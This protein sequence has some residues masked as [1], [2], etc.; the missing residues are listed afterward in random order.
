M[1]RDEIIAANPI[2][3]FVRSRGHKMI[4]SGDNFITAACPV[5]VH[6]KPGHYPVT[7]DVAKQVW[8]C[9]DHKVGCSIIDW[10]KTEKNISAI[11]AMREL[12]GGE[13]KS[14]PRKEFVCA[15]DYTDESGKL[16]SQTVRYKLPSPENKTFSQRQPND[17]GGWIWNLKGVRCVLYR[18]REVVAAQTVIVVEG[19]KNADDLAALGFVATTNVFGA[20]KWR[21]EYSE[22]LRGK[23]VVV[24][25]DIGDPDQAG[26][27][28]TQKV[29]HSLAGKAG[30]LKH[31]IQ[32]NGFHDVSDWI[33]ALPKGEA[34]EAIQKLINETPLINQVDLWQQ[35]TT[36]Q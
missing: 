21:D 31:A 24:F 36:A 35:A 27:R 5:G 16:L 7:I 17:K 33:A 6:K 11:N 10:I 29:L 34:K 28:H 12:G 23:D 18:L 2:V 19:E 14:R 8:H 9:N 13:N 22:T 15:Y 3:D 4:A 1:S 25:G 30:S 32:P 26:E 20:G